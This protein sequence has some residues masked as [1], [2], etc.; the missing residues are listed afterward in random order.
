MENNNN[1]DQDY[2]KAQA[3]VEELKNFYNHLISFIVINPF[4]IF[5]N[6][7]TF[8]DF[9]WFWFSLGGWGLGLLIHALTTFGVSRNWEERKIRE[10]MDKEDF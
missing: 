5:V 10:L 6:Y 1:L 7:M 3:R 8:W 2:L 4:L 9:K